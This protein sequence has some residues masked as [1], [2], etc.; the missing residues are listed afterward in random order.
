[1]ENNHYSYNFYNKRDQSGKLISY[2]ARELSR[3]LTDLSIKIIN[4]YESINEIKKIIPS[5]YIDFYF[6]K[7]IYYKLLLEFTQK[8]IIHNFDNNDSK[9][10]I[11]TYNLT[12]NDLSGLPLSLVRDVLKLN[13]NKITININAKNYESL[14]IK[15]FIKKFFLYFRSSFY[16]FYK[17]KKFNKEK[18]F[19]GI[20]YQE[21][22]NNNSRS[23]FSW[24]KNIDIKPSDIIYY[25]Q[26]KKL[27]KDINR[28]KKDFLEMINLGL[29][30]IE[31]WKYENQFI[32]KKN[33]F[34]CKFNKN[35]DEIEKWIIK[36][37][38]NL[39][40]KCNYW[41]NFFSFF[42]IKVHSD[43]TEFGEDVIAKHISINRLGGCTFGR[44]RSYPN[45]IK[46]A[47]YCLFLNDLFF[48]WGKD[49]AERMKLTSNQND[50][51][52]VTGYV[53]GGPSNET[54]K[55]LENLKEKFTNIGVEKI[56]L[57]VDSISQSS[58]T[59]QKIHKD[60]YQSFFIKLLKIIR[61]N[62]KIGLIIKPK[63]P[64]VNLYK[65]SDIINQIENLER[66]FLI[67]NERLDRLK[68]YDYATICNF[69][70]GIQPQ[71]SS[72][73]LESII[74]CKKGVFYD[75]GNIKDYETKIYSEIKK[76]I[77]SSNSDKTIEII[78]KYINDKNISNDY[79]NWSNLIDSIDS[80][81]DG[82]G[83]YRMGSYIN[84]IYKGYKNKLDKNQIIDLAN[85]EYSQIYGNE[86]II[87]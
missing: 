34:T 72:A 13:N 4:N 14:N 15:L 71:I 19:I 59:G 74:V 38:K 66:C 36:E 76:D 47:Q 78:N 58:G 37:L 64:K 29:K 21:G 62:K 80:F 77:I 25:I 33:E 12:H 26:N 39:L 82:K 6:R 54:K 87:N 11:K 35:K 67:K 40:N 57:F 45:N 79:C 85:R 23:D 20:S 75:Y 41:Y 65:Y 43:P 27:L 8:Y 1:M 42:N 52:V 53:W 17:N 55:E 68:P 16:F 7:K 73:F 30:F 44:L 50:N 84:Y 2:Q 56:I 28:N 69:V 18:E 10:G 48:L 32:Y 3:K 5:K 51:I 22:I 63:K 46:S 49:S 83:N 24:L 81:N 70:V 86:M 60:D 61:E 9:I 31:V